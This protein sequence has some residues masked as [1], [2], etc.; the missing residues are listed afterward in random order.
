MRFG[1]IC[2]DMRLLTVGPSDLVVAKCRKSPDAKHN[3]PSEAASKTDAHHHHQRR[4]AD[5]LQR[6]ESRAAGRLQPRMAAECRCL[7][8]PDAPSRLQRLSRHWSRPA[9]PWPLKPTLAW[10]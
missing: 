8:G 7:R 10:Q 1:T 6:L 2:T 9:R 5:L 3:D 4:N